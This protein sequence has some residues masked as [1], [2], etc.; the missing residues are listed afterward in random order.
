MPLSDVRVLI[1]LQEK[2][3]QFIGETTNYSILRQLILDRKEIHVITEPMIEELKRLCEQDKAHSDKIRLNSYCQLQQQQ[4]AEEAA[5][6]AAQEKKEESSFYQLNYMTL[7]YSLN[8]MKTENVRLIEKVGTIKEELNSALKLS[9][10]P[11]SP[12]INALKE[13]LRTTRQALELQTSQLKATEKD[14]QKLETQLNVIFPEHKRQ[15][16]NR[17]TQRQARAR[18]PNSNSQLSAENLLKLQEQNIQE[19]RQ[20]NQLKSQLIHQIQSESHS[21]YLRELRNALTS[22]PM[23]ICLS[24]HECQVLVDLLNGLK[25]YQQTEQNHQKLQADLSAQ[26]GELDRAVTKLQH[27]TQ[28]VH[29]FPSMKDRLS[30]DNIQLETENLDLAIK[31]PK[32]DQNVSNS[33]NLAAAGG[34]LSLAGLGMRNAQRQHSWFLAIPVIAG[35]ASLV[36]LTFGLG[37]KYKKRNHDKTIE[38]NLDAMSYS[39]Q[40]IITEEEVVKDL[41][42]AKI[43]TQKEVIAAFRASI[44]EK[45]AAL[46]ADAE[47]MQNEW[48][49]LESIDI[50]N[51]PN[52]AREANPNVFFLGAAAATCEPSAPPPPPYYSLR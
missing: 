23:S 22:S 51:S 16:E 11:E 34:V 7:S 1:Q 43:P 27:D 9:T 20:L 6:D 24:S 26:Q 2:T 42:E 19:H 47:K 45:T 5:Q 30:R 29:D 14:F 40:K 21:V 32:I 52:F 25:K 31:I 13:H 33:F 36:A 18:H 50:Q 46:N 39:R 41:S 35:I 37:Y 48:R 38:K 15:R 49:Q 12:N 4:D 28:R 3:K 44:V 17:K 8:S 10:D